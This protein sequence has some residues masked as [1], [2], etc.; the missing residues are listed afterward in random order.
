MHIVGRLHLPQFE[1][2]VEYGNRH[3][4]YQKPGEPPFNA[5]SALSVGD[6]A[7]DDQTENTDVDGP[8]HGPSHDEVQGAEAS[9]L[10]E[11]EGQNRHGWQQLGRT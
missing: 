3:G 7:G 8:V 4:N 5:V 11:H 10:V 1:H 6:I 9:E 2:A